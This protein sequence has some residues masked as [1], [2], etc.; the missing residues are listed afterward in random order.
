M[1]DDR[2]YVRK[3]TRVFALFR[4]S[5]ETD[6]VFV[7]FFLPSVQRVR[8]LLSLQVLDI[9]LFSYDISFPRSLLCWIRV[10]QQ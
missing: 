9:C 3:D 10:E 8:R 6:D 1:T 5:D 2:P 7:L 4:S